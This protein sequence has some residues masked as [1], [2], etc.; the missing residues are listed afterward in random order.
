MKMPPNSVTA[1]N[2]MDSKNPTFS[3]APMISCGMIVS[4]VPFGPVKT[5]VNTHLDF[6]EI[7]LFFSHYFSRNLFDKMHRNPLQPM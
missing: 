2:G 4:D 3:T 6:S 5:F 1:H 7:K